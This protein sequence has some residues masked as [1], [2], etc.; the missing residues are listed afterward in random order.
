MR[1]EETFLNVWLPRET[2]AILILYTYKFMLTSHEPSLC[3][4]LYGRNGFTAQDLS[5]RWAV[6]YY[7]GTKTCAP[8]SK[9]RDIFTLICI[10]IL[11]GCHLE[12]CLFQ[13]AY[14]D[15]SLNAFA[16]II[17]KIF[18]QLLLLPQCSPL[19][20]RDTDTIVLPLGIVYIKIFYHVL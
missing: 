12:N 2:F 7:W 14:N 8:T 17:C 13:S 9:E 4:G 19:L 20:H 11:T 16:Y 3:V 5:M 6:R 15:F 1:R 18:K 10:K